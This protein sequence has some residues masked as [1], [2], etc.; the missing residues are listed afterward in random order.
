[1]NQIL[2]L[3]YI[4]GD[5]LN[6]DLNIHQDCT[7]QLEPEIIENILNERGV[8][9]VDSFL[10]PDIEKDLLPLDA[11]KNIDKAAQIVSEGV[12]QNKSFLVF[13]DVDNDGAS[14]CAIMVRY[15]R[16]LGVDPDWTINQGKIH[17]TNEQFLQYV[18][19]TRPKVIIIVDSLD[20]GVEG[21]RELKRQ[22]CDVIVLDH[23]MISSQ[24]PYDTY[25][26]LVSSM[27]DYENSALSGAGVVWKFCKYLDKNIFGT[28]EADNLVDLAMSGIVGDM[29]D[30]SESAKENRAII[31]YG[32]KN[33]SNLALKAIGGGF[34]FNSSTIA[35]SVSP[36]VNACNRMNRNELP[37]KA[38]LSDNKAEVSKF[39]KELNKTKDEQNK[40]V[41][42]L[43]PNCI[44]Q[45]N[46]QAN[47]KMIVVITEDASGVNGLLGNK[48]MNIYKRPILVLKE[49]ANEYSGSARSCGMEDFKTMCEETELCACAGHELAFGIS[50]PFNCF[51]EFRQVIEERLSEIEFVDKIDVDCELSVDD[52]TETFITKVKD[53]DRISGTGFPPLT[54]SVTIDDYEVSD[55]S[56]GKHL[57]LKTPNVWFIKWNFNGN[58]EEL[59][60]AALFNTPIQCIGTLDSGRI[61]RNYVK[62]MIMDQFIIREDL[63]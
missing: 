47:K 6:Y 11:L 46:L 59:E 55:M 34:D 44:E 40:L 5:I 36:R 19:D 4:G 42:S 39:V 45:A 52:L 37:V 30:V 60:E 17:G 61:G 56:K 23:H 15:L 50:I 18:S 53:I 2:Y 29:M 1:M 57:V 33:V 32:L 54:F 12:G 7:A 24:E 10:H 26:T 28:M 21:Y 25:I 9:D 31:D 62:R 13:A 14:A 16:A 51:Q 41:D 48:L 20:E 49:G 22:G 43:F 58:W 35:F 38:L 3:I 63:L 27:N 8:K